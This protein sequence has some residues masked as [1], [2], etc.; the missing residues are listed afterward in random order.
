MGK[1]MILRDG[2]EARLTLTGRFNVETVGELKASIEK[3]FGLDDRVI[4]SVAG[5]EEA[6]ASLYQLMCSA[7]KSAKEN[8]KEIVLDKGDGGTFEILADQLGF[9]RLRGCDPERPEKCLWI[10]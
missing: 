2:S 6:D 5:I 4:L 8:S 3:A 7:H 10:K 9:S 1:I